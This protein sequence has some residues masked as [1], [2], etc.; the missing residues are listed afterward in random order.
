MGVKITIDLNSHKRDKALE[1]N[2]AILNK[3]EQEIN[4]W[5]NECLRQDAEREIE[6]Q[7]MFKKIREEKEEELTTKIAGKVLSEYSKQEQELIKKFEQEAKLQAPK[8]YETE[9]RIAKDKH[10]LIVKK[11]NYLKKT[12]ENNLSHI[13]LTLDGEDFA[14]TNVA[15]DALIKILEGPFKNNYISPTDVSR[16]NNEFKKRIG[17]IGISRKKKGKNYELAKHIIC[18]ELLND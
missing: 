11:G 5:K 8:M 2:M 16:L 1:E 14:L 7:L 18:R 17:K 15:K 3:T 10:V 6:R 9:Q 13:E 4:A 12:K